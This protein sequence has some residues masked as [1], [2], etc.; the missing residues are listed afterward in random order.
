METKKV[1]EVFVANELKGLSAH[2]A[3]VFA[4]ERVEY[5]M[6]PAK[7]SLANFA[8]CFFAEHEIRIDPRCGLKQ[9]SINLP[10]KKLRFCYLSPN[11]FDRELR[12][13]GH[14]LDSV[15]WHTFV[16]NF[17]ITKSAKKAFFIAVDSFADAVYSDMQ[18][19]YSDKS[20]LD[21]LEKTG[22][23]FTKNGDF[24]GESCRIATGFLK[25]A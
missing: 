6:T 18:E 12:P 21:I 25:S 22:W 11:Y 20:M 15:L 24:A 9:V 3:C 5:D 1:V 16:D 4:R 8:R 14:W 17:R 10:G 19:F 7:M 13:T 23:V 2:T